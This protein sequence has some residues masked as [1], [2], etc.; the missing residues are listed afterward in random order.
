MES[1][2]HVDIRP[3]RPVT[4]DPILREKDKFHPAMAAK[5]PTEL[6]SATKARFMKARNDIDA[7]L[8]KLDGDVPRAGDELVVVPLGTNSAISSRYRNGGYFLNSLS[9]QLLIVEQYQVNLFKFQIGATS[10][11]TLAR[12]HGV[13]WQDTLGQTRLGLRMFGRLCAG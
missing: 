5:A 2:S 9:L 8:A 6:P 11:S 13:R 1:N 4:I 7:R 10:C 12:E 3:Q